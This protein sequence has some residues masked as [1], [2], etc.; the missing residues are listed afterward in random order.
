MRTAGSWDATLANLV[1]SRTQSKPRNE[2]D[3]EESEEEE[4]LSAGADRM[5]LMV[6]G[7]KHVGKSTFAKLVVNR[8]L[9]KC[10][11]R[12]KSYFG[13]ADLLSHVGTNAW[14][15][16]MLTWANPSSRRPAWSR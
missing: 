1:P 16:L 3:S 4:D 15:T 6:E 10:A 5:V 14:R 2:D 13:L 7:P 11:S 12:P 8:L 9:S